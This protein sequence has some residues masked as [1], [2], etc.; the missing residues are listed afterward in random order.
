MSALV[1]TSKTESVT[2]SSAVR[3][4]PADGC[5]A[6]WAMAAATGNQP[7]EAMIN[8]GWTRFMVMKRK[9][10]GNGWL[11]CAGLKGAAR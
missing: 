1:L 2:G 5:G 11:G 6:D 7:S 10:K 8:A 4:D 9:G 3:A